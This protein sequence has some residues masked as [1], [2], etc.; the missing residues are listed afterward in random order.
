MTGE[1]LSV[2]LEMMH[3]QLDVGLSGHTK[4]ELEG[5]SLRGC[6]DEENGMGAR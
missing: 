2:L 5:C 3:L 1:G 4:N 6:I